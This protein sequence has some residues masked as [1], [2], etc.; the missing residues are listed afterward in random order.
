MNWLNKKRWDVLKEVIIL[1][2][3]NNNY[4]KSTLNVTIKKRSKSKYRN[5]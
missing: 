4:S 3:I 1:I 5:S 2:I